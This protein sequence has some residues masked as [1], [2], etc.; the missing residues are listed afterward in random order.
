[1]SE[2]SG[3]DLP[4]GESKQDLDQPYVDLTE[5]LSRL[6]DGEAADIYA[7]YSEGISNDFFYQE[8]VDS[9]IAKGEEESIIGLDEYVKNHINKPRARKVVIER[10]RHDLGFY[11][12]ASETLEEYKT[13]LE[14]SFLIR[15]NLIENTAGILFGSYYGARY[16]YYEELEAA[17]MYQGLLE[18]SLA[19]ARRQD[20]DPVELA[21]TYLETIDRQAAKEYPSVS[22]RNTHNSNRSTY[23]GP[24]NIFIYERFGMKSGRHEAPTESLGFRPFGATSWQDF[25]QQNPNI[26]N[27]DPEA[28]FLAAVLDAENMI[29][30]QRLMTQLLEVS[31]IPLDSQNIGTFQA[32]EKEL[33]ATEREQLPQGA[34]RLIRVGMDT[35]ERVIADMSSQ[36]QAKPEDGAEPKTTF[37][38]A[39]KQKIDQAK[40]ESGLAISDVIK[41]ANVITPLVKKMSGEQ[42]LKELNTK[43]LLQLSAAIDRIA[44]FVLNDPGR[45]KFHNAQEAVWSTALRCS[46]LLAEVGTDRKHNQRVVSFGDLAL[47]LSIGGTL[48]K[49]E[50]KD[51]AKITKPGTQQSLAEAVYAALKARRRS[52]RY[53]L[54]ESGKGLMS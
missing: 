22:S 13:R 33:V 32:I 23:I 34:G 28:I 29:T 40:S 46:S 9:K 47:K 35:F 42:N 18:A 5:P 20:I 41:L 48:T 4:V 51:L 43:D 26:P 54:H 17:R 8:Y 53:G 14:N 37:A 16:G 39:I 2:T 11:I 3:G 30:N 10:I 25:I 19:A 12:S 31:Y 15:P 1:M 24:V 36:V 44:Y 49:K 21:V 52:A 50:A 6:A 27:D 45:L 7:L 38:Q